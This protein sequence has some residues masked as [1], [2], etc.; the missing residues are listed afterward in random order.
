MVNETKNFPMPALVSVGPEQ[1]LERAKANGLV[2]PLNG[3]RAYIFGASPSGLTPQAWLA[4][5]QFWEMYFSAAD[6]DLAHTQRS[7]MSS[8]DLRGH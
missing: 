3:Y 8:A 6:A 5:K 7:A 2:V 1:M 4:V